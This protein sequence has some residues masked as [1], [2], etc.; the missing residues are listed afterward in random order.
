MARKSLQWFFTHGRINDVPEGLTLSIL[1]DPIWEVYLIGKRGR[2]SRKA[3]VASSD[4]ACINWAGAHNGNRHGMYNGSPVYRLYYEYFCGRIPG[5][6]ELHHDCRN[7]M[8]VNPFHLV[9]MT[10]AEHKGSK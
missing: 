5:G 10:R 7:P 6:R 2:P 9:P 8:C 3:A 4:S 1:V